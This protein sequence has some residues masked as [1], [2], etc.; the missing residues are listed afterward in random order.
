MNKHL[1]LAEAIT[2]HVRPGMHLNFASTPVRSNVAIRELA[3]QFRQRA[4]GFTFS[5]TGFHSTAHLLGLLR[6]GRRYIGCFFGD[7]HPTPRPNFL[8]QKLLSEGATLE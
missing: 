8:Y 2:R 7:N 3:R 1:P 5:A 6:L 4:P